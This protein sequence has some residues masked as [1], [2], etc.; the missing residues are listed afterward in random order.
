MHPSAPTPNHRRG[1]ALLAFGVTALGLTLGACSSTDTAD[2]PR[3][4]CP[5]EPVSVVATVNQWGQIVE[6][7]G[8]DCVTVDSIISGS[9]ADPHDYEPTPA[10]SAA[11]EDADLAVLNGLGYDS[12]AQRA[13]DQVGDGPAVIVAGDVAG[14]TTGDNPH[15]W[16]S[17]EAVRAMTE[18][19]TGELAQ[20][21][22]LGPDAG[23]YLGERFDAWMESL[24]SYDDAIDGLAKAGDGAT[25]ASTE[26]VADDLLEAAG[27]SNV[28]PPG[29]RSAALNETEPSPSDLAAFDDL[30]ASG[31]VD[32]LV[33][34]PQSEGP[35]ADQL[36][37]SADGDQ[38]PVVEVTETVPDDA[39]GFVAWQVAQLNSL[40]AA[41]AQ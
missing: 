8:G 31:K 28:T 26:P 16:Y 7:L 24:Q 2:A 37:R 27:L 32:L 25:F 29:Y 35:V 3:G 23:G 39:D 36:R 5:V 34:N 19:I 17:P 38:V 41:L 33:V 30:L 13:L 18:A 12:W 20:L 15:I 21:T 4:D 14:R 6:Q 9:A 1:W 11:F 40:T 10:D 22:P